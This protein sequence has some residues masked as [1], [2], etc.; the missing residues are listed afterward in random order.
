MC[1]KNKCCNVGGLRAGMRIS[2]YMTFGNDELRLIAQT[3][4]DEFYL[5]G[6]TSGNRCCDKAKTLDQLKEYLDSEHRG[7][8]IVQ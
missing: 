7:W 4:D 3:G 1:C 6:L 5:V 2:S 8:R